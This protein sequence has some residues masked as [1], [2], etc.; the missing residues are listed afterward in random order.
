MVVTI[1]AH[2]GDLVYHAR[3]YLTHPRIANSF[4]CLRL[5]IYLVRGAEAV[6]ARLDPQIRAREAAAYQDETFPWSWS[7]C[8]P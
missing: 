1:Y 4:F 8:K 5:V 6:Q 2:Y 3:V 7:F